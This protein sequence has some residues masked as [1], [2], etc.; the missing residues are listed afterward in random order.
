MWRIDRRL[1]RVA[2]G[3]EDVHSLVDGE[4][5]LTGA[6]SIGIGRKLGAGIMCVAPIRL[7][8]LTARSHRLEDLKPC[9]PTKNLFLASE[10]G[11]VRTNLPCTAA[12]S[13]SARRLRGL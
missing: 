13:A 7:P 9:H 12:I 10:E 11:I 5:Q 6:A 2:F 3:M 8:C 1:S 4:V